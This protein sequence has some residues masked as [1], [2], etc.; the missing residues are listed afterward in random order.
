[1]VILS[2]FFK[3]KIDTKKWPPMMRNILHTQQWSKMVLS[4][5]TWKNALLNSFGHYI[6]IYDK[7]VG[8][9]ILEGLDGRPDPFSLGFPSLLDIGVMGHCHNN[10]SFC[11]QGFKKQPHMIFDDFKRIIKEASPYVS[12]C[13][14]GG[15]GDPNKYP[16][17]KEMV[18]FCRLHN[19][20]PSYTTSGRNLSEEEIDISSRYCAAVAVSD[21]GKDYTYDALN[22]LIEAGIKTSIH[23]VVNKKS[24]PTVLDILNGKDVWNGRVNMKKLNAVIF[25]LFKPQGMGRT[26]KRNMW[27]LNAAE[28]KLLAEAFKK[29]KTKFLVGMDSCLANHVIRNRSLSP[30]EEFCYSTCEGA[31]MSCYITP[32]M[33]LVPCSF[34]NHDKHGI[35]L[36]PFK[37]FRRSIRNAW[38][39]GKPFRTFRS[40]LKHIPACCPYEELGEFTSHH[41]V[42]N[43]G[44]N[45]F[46]FS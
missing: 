2:K 9:E 8:N 4:P 14:L 16:K 41:E 21:Y 42:Q 20:A 29:P 32:D 40:I 46:L 11:Y 5:I 26:I 25:L 45:Q 3:D 43:N 6:I 24:F 10:C 27:R 33:R 28:F 35:N 31:R 18:A 7:K 34:G 30:N 36:K 12:Q 22:K 17:F 1:M 13:A 23:F 15:R 39:Y 38:T 37:F 19:V 44:S